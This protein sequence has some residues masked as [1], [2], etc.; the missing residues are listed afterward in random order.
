M[1]V[2]AD[3]GFT[4]HPL[5]SAMAATGAHLCWRA[6]GNAVLPV[7]ER[8]PD[9]SYRSELVA[10]TDKRTRQGVLPVRVIEYAIEDPGRSPG[11]DLTYRLVTTLLDPARAPA[12]ELAALYSE[13]WEFESAL[14]ELK[15]HQ[16]GPRVVMRS[17]T[18]DGVYQEAW[19]M[20]CVHYAIR[21]LLCRAARHGDVD[22]DRV[23]FTRTLR[24]ARR[25][26]RRAVGDGVSLSLGLVRA[27]AEILEELLPRR[28]LR[29][30]PRVVRRK[31]SNFLVKRAE[32]RRWPQPTIPRLEAIRTLSP[33]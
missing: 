26:V 5:F 14:D 8:H 12:R 27:I 22:P 24:A 28:R 30:N 21:A 2:L 25:S 7:L 15:T 18:S 10:S 9:G 33:P 4:A 20:L 13:R 17:K 3:R 16:T 23:S 6:K 31:M 19:G 11:E 32:H 29:A 1:L